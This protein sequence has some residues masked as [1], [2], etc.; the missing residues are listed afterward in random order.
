MTYSESRNAAAMRAGQH[1]LDNAAPPEWEDVTDYL[2]ADD[3]DAARAE[4]I[5]D[6]YEP[7]ELTDAR[8]EQRAIDNY[9][10][11]W[12]DH[13]PAGYMEDDR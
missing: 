1:R 11:K 10:A 12:A 4:L 7:D 3:Y 6:G 9:L 5:D 8:I 13:E 2:D